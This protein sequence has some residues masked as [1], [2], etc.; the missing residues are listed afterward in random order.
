V[1]STADAKLARL[2]ERGDLDGAFFLY[3]D[4]DR[5]RDEAVS[6]L[7]D[8]AVDPAM[9]DFNLDVFRGSEVDPTD[10]ASALA[11]LPMMAE[12]RVVVLTEAQQLTPRGRKLVQETLENLPPGLCFILSATIP[13]RSKA[14]FYR[15]LK[16][17]AV[18]AEWKT[19]AYVEIPGWLM[20]RARVR[21]GFEL[22][23]DAASAMAGAVGSN[24]GV[25]DAELGKLASAADGSPITAEVVRDLVPN[26]KS[27]DRW[28]W[29]DEVAGR[30][31]ETALA[32]LPSLLSGGDSTVGLLMAM[33]EHHL[34]VGL[35]LEGGAA[36][37]GR[38]LTEAGRPYLKWKT[39]SYVA[40]AGNWTP[41]HLERAL[42]LLGRADARARSSMGG[43]RV[44]TDL[45]LALRVLAQEAA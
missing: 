23:P 44:M 1:T 20:E 24:V 11:T 3:G 45:L 39:K 43:G 14:A 6:A 13:E 29:L 38:T 10:L 12:R 25:L 27:V 18:A 40:Q 35:A 15:V 22:T 21:H 26:V 34:Y 4:A 9:R 5:L 33:V 17:R 28:A 30:R 31:Y 37:L 7:I 16:R 42:E 8:A 2:L 36:L 41:Q 19:P 32:Q